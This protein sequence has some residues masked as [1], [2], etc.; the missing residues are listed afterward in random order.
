MPLSTQKKADNEGVELNIVF[1]ITGLGQGGAETM[2]LKLLQNIDRS[3][4]SPQVVTLSSAGEL[5]PAITAL[6][7]PVV[8]LNMARNWRALAAVPRLIRHLR[9]EKPD[10]VHTWMYHADLLGGIAARA[11]G[12]RELVWGIRHSNLSPAVNK[13]ST[14]AVVALC[15]RLSHWLPK[16]ILVC[17]EAARR[18]HVA[19]GYSARKM[20]VIPNGFDIS[21]F[22]SEPQ[23][24]DAVRKEL[25][26]AP[27]ALLIG[28]VARFDPQKNHVGFLQAMGLLHPQWPTAHFLLAGKGIDR[29]NRPLLEAARKAGIDGH[30]H[31]IGPRADIPRVMAS[32]DV[33]VSPSHGEA[34]PNVLGEAMACEIP[35]VVTDVGDCAYIIG[36]TG[37]IVTRSDDAAGLADATASVLAMSSDA[38]KALG[39]K[40]RERV[41]EHFEIRR[42]VSM[43][44]NFY[45]KTASTDRF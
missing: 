24:R 5:G 38:R 41:T 23:A 17:S 9:T 44:E 18:A 11:A 22:K 42:V 35:C 20:A 10:I 29:N 15:A 45:C 40:A 6:G 13:R 14:L 26:L 8:A 39:K 21:R 12:L 28:V 1:V 25:G 3:K 36:D 19:H 37:R 16:S 2:L 43:F 7:I 4:F 32:L 31:F 27:D 34:F 33:L 30:C